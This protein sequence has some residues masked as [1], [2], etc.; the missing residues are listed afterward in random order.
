MIEMVSIAQVLNFRK[1]IKPSVT[2]V[3]FASLAQP[4]RGVAMA[5]GGK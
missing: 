5:R 1:T 3:R 4:V 2:E